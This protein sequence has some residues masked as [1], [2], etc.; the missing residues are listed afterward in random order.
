MIHWMIAKAALAL[1]A[2]AGAPP[3][4]PAWEPGA[5]T[6]MAGSVQAAK[7]A[8]HG[9]KALGADVEKW[10]FTPLWQQQHPV[11]AIRSVCRIAHMAGEQC[12]AAP[13]LDLFG[14]D[15]ARY[16]ASGVT[17]A[18]RYADVWEIQAQSKELNVPV[19]Q[20]FVHAAARQARHAHPGIVV[21]AGLTTSSR[22]GNVT[23]WKLWQAFTAVR[24]YVG[25]YWGNIPG[26]G[27]RCPACGTPDPWPMVYVLRRAT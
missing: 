16:L 25:G 10:S 9:L 19:Y 13:A 8:P 3:V 15:P 22:V 7:A 11:R 27:P 2:A 18:A 21:L 23:G 1:L 26:A 12:I 6:I 20:A 17:R 5:G 4:T 24:P 14:G